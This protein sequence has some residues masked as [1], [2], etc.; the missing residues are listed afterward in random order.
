MPSA[1]RPVPR[2]RVQAQPGQASPPEQVLP[3]RE[4]AW[5]EPQQQPVP[6]GLQVQ[7]RVAALRA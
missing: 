2:W 3:G 6:P 5:Q 1:R 7:P 4:Q